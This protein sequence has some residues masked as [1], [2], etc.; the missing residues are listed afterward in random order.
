MRRNST[1]AII[2]NLPQNSVYYH[3][4][5]FLPLSL[6]GVYSFILYVNF[7]S[8]MQKKQH[9]HV[10][11]QKIAHQAWKIAHLCLCRLHVFPTIGVGGFR[12]Y[13]YVFLSFHIVTNNYAMP[14]QG[15]NLG[16]G[17]KNKNIFLEGIMQY[18]VFFVKCFMLNK[19]LKL[20]STW[21]YFVYS[22]QQRRF[23][24]HLLLS[25]LK[26]ISEFGIFSEF[27]QPICS[28]KYFEVQLFWFANH[29]EWT[30]QMKIPNSKLVDN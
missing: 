26:V 16:L 7:H 14:S 13:F 2:Q 17:G 30:S 15:E 28:V 4:K 21:Q 3:N 12:S 10:H 27:I 19:S 8:K 20:N 22:Y 6:Q 9:L 29:T 25:S 18:S 23:R 24:Y 5:H 1:E 11:W